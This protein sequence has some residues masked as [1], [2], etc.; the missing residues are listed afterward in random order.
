MAYNLITS[1]ATE[2]DIDNAVEWYVD[3][4]TDIAR[5]FL[6]ELKAVKKYISKNPEKIQIRYNNVRVAF[7]KNFPYGVH[8]TFDNSSIIIVAVFNTADD[9]E[10]WEER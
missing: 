3:I 6:A 4:R 10:K 1:L 8:Y 9:P 5:Q 7:L 2:K